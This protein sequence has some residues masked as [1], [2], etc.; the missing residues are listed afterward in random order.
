M[1]GSWRPFRPESLIRGDCV[2][3]GSLDSGETALMPQSA[4]GLPADLCGTRGTGNDKSVR[5]TVPPRENSGNCDTQSRG[6][7]SDRGRPKPNERLGE[8][9]RVN[10]ES[11]IAS[12]PVELLAMTVLN[13]VK[14]SR[15]RREPRRRID[16]AGLLRDQP[17]VLDAAVLREVEQGFLVEA[18]DV[19]VAFGGKHL[20]SLGARQCDDLS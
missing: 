2:Y 12:S 19:E 5:R 1:N 9:I 6:H 17:I 16:G 11:G 18:A 4:D 15:H 13:R 3:A 14:T 8:P 10:C 7:L 20:V